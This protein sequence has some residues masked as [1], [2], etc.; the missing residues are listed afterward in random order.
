MKPFHLIFTACAFAVLTQVLGQT[1]NPP[2]TLQ[3]KKKSVSNPVRLT[4]PTVKPKQATMP[5]LKPFPR[6]TQK[7][8]FISGDQV[9]LVGDGLIEQTQKLGYM[10][11]RITVQNSGKKLHF[12]NIGWSGDTPAGIAR[13]GLGTRQAG[14]EPANEGWLQL[15]KQITDIK[16]TVA[17]IGYGMASS[18]DTGTLEQFKS[19]YQRL[20]EQIKASAGKENPLRLVFMSPIAHENLGGKLPSGE[21]HNEVLEKFREVIR[22][23]SKEHDAWFVDLYRYLSRR[24]GSGTPPLTTDGIHLNDYGYWMMASVA[25]FSFNWKT[26]NFRFGITDSGTERNGGYGI[27]LVNLT[28]T[29]NG[30]TLD[31][32]F[33][34]LPSYYAQEKKNKPLTEKTAIGWI[35]FMGLPEGRYTLAADNV[36]IH[37]AD[38]KEWGGGVFIDAGPDIDQ[39]EEL[40]R[41]LVEK[42]DLFFHRSR[43]Q[44]QAYLWGFR[45]HEQGNYAIKSKNP[46]YL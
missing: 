20:V 34:A 39:A 25:E 30:M 8:N 12:H 31:G 42:N 32:Q 35:Q 4:L 6:K 38:A 24:K 7:L 5:A 40:R 44:N 11:Y 43:P 1:P 14:H 23:L 16:P 29:P 27:K 37:T 46:L 15:R 13:D 33:E 19:D 17:I 9:L 21:E 22:D 10:E 2:V 36:E 45:R 26:T 18:L 28:R 41:L 3:P